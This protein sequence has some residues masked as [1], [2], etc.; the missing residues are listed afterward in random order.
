MEDEAAARK[1][2]VLIATWPLV[3]KGHNPGKRYVG[4]G[5]QL[6][7][8]D[9]PITTRATGRPRVETEFG[10]RDLHKVNSKC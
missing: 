6:I 1:L 3:T 7:L 4:Q 5:R 10:L 8:S 2:P 9:A